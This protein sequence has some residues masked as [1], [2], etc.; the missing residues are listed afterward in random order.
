MMSPVT[1]TGTTPLLY[2]EL[3]TLLADCVAFQSWV[4]AVDAAAAKASIYVEGFTADLPTKRPFALLGIASQTHDRQSGGVGITYA[5]RREFVIE[6]ETD[7]TAGDTEQDSF[8]RFMNAIDPIIEEMMAKSDTNKSPGVEYIP[9]HQ[10]V[11]SGGPMVS[12]GRRG[13]NDGDSVS[14]EYTLTVGILSG[15]EGGV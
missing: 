15:S 13:D 11:G 12:Q 1:A 2:E 9:I 8:Y 3:I 6:F 4:G 5:P 7:L 10:V 14:I